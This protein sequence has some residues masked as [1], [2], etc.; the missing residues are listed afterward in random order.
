MK[1]KQGTGELIE[2]SEG[3]SQ[4]WFFIYAYLKSVL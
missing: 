4:L 3:N 2:S 1:F